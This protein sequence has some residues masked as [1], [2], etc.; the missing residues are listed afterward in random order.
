ME[1]GDPVW[2]LIGRANEA[3]R[4]RSGADARLIL[5]SIGTFTDDM[6]TFVAMIILL[7]AAMLEGDLIKASQYVQ[8]LKNH[9]LM[10]EPVA[11]ATANFRIASFKR[12][13]L[14]FD[15]ALTLQLHAASQFRHIG[16]K[17][18]EALC[19]TEIG[20]IMLLR[21]D[22]TGALQSYMSVMD[23]IRE[24]GGDLLYAPLLGNLAT[25]LERSGNE[26]EAERQYEAILSMSPFSHSGM[27]RANVLINL[28]VISKRRAR[29]QEAERYYRE[30]MTCIADTQ[31]TASLIRIQTSMAEMFAMRG[32]VEDAV[33][34]LDEL[35]A[36][37]QG[38]IHTGIR[39]QMLS[40]EVLILRSK[41][42][43]EASI[44]KLRC[45]IAM[46]R[47]SGLLDELYGLLSDSL[48]WVDEP[49]IRME[50]LEQYRQ[51][52]DERHR[53][54][55]KSINAII[56]LRAYLEQ[57]RARLELERQLE[58]SHVILDTQTRT[59]NEIGRELHDSVGQ[60]MTVLLRITERLADQRDIPQ[61][62]LHR[63][64]K[65]V[66]EVTRRASADTRR[67]AH[68]LAASGV[69]GHG[70]IEALTVM[71]DEI[72]QAQPDLDLQ[73]VVTGPLDDM[74][75]ASARAIYRV[76][77]TLLQNVLKHS[78]AS[79]C[80]VNIVV[81]DTYYHLG[82][83]DDG[84]GFDPNVAR[85]GMGLREMKARIELVGGSVRIESAPG[86][87]AYIEVSVPRVHGEGR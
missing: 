28:A 33:R 38:H 59:M 61:D 72:R 4:N 75:F 54:V 41:G 83:E 15:E 10:N 57:E 65:T 9:A 46:A 68:L 2:S 56:D 25:A 40:I 1:Y 82:V 7:R 22:V 73:V 47:D 24:E 18:E 8:E 23:V 80:S 14:E 16:W 43:I 62:E 29:Y 31:A 52:Q 51:V 79:C 36:A 85:T 3:I 81:H 27:D 20:S 86:R 84:K 42:N 50:L 53:S 44:E 48:E 70:L 49:S 39:L 37:D 21:G 26:V 67:I 11:A 58:V 78:D 13:R 71:R 12:L 60:D 55:S 76:V 17:L 69:S 5:E 63:M 32:E 35:R 19:I 74:S 34:I 30:A 64:L 87:G 45:A 77:Q 6:Q 66:A